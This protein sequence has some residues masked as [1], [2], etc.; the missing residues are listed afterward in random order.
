[1]RELD[2]LAEPLLE[3]LPPEEPGCRVVAVGGG[4]GLAQALLAVQSYAGEITAV[5]SVADDGGSSGRLT[6][7]GI[8]PPGDCRRALLALS[9]DRSPWWEAVGHRFRAGDVAGHSLGNLIL[10]AL[11][12]DGAGLEEALYTLGLLLGAR[13]RVIPAAPVALT[14]EAVIDGAEVTGQVAI[15][16]ARGELSRLRVLP[17][18]A[19]AS[20]SA[21]EALAAADQVVVGPGSLFTSLAAALVVP[22]MVEAVNAS[23]GRLVYVCNLTTQDGE[24]LGM[25]A[26]DH[27]ASLC[28]ITGL[29]APEVV[30]AN[31]APFAV[32]ASVEPVSADRERIKALGAH[33]EAAELADPT[34]DWPQHD[35]ARLGAVLRRLP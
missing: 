8:P 13:G 30:V 7:L 19:E 9:P 1:M 23:P 18:G 2:L 22:G 6:A 32:P 21:R 20:P 27:V 10:A 28:R 11:A 35:P 31:S 15:A 4:H 5:V 3:E 25:D 12:A 26:G 17:P 33:L 29:R 24:T 14:L 16:L 34:A